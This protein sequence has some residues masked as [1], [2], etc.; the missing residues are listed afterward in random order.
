MKN[1]AE[2]FH[3]V[4]TSKPSGIILMIFC[5]ALLWLLL[6]AFCGGKKSWR[7][8]NL[9]LA[10]ASLLAICY[11]TLLRRGTAEYDA[12]WLPFRS[13]TVAKERPEVNR[14][15]LMNV[16]LF[17]PMGRSLPFALPER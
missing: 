7:T 15:M 9:C 10:A 13:F 4:Y 8:A 16:F 14:S 3:S 12:Y 2:L 1:L 11:T 5:G 6:V 17:S